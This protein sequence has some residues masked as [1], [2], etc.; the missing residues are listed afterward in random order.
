MLSVQT[1]FRGTL[2]NPSLRGSID[3]ITMTNLTM[4]TLVL[5]FYRGV[6]TELYEAYK[7][8]DANPA[9]G[10]LLLCGNALRNNPLLRSLC[11][12]LFGREACLT[13]RKEETATGAALLAMRSRKF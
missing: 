6:L 7:K 1:L 9:Q 8:M 5:G 4:G 11:A 2:V 13:D 12:E 3:G 10:R